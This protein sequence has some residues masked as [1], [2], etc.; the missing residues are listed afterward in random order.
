[1]K[2]P[3]LIAFIMALLIAGAA[4]TYLYANGQQDYLALLA[5]GTTVILLL[6]AY[7][8]IGS[9]AAK[10]HVQHLL[11]L[12]PQRVGLLFFAYLLPYLLFSCG[13]QTFSTPAL[14]K[15]AVF[16]GMPALILCIAK[17][18][19]SPVGWPEAAAMFCIWLPF[20][21]GLL[22]DIWQWPKGESAYVLNAT[23]AVGYAVALFCCYRDVRGVGFDFTWSKEHSKAVVIN[24]T[25]FFIIALAFGI[26]TGFIH[27]NGH[28]NLLKLLGASVG[29]FVFI[30]LPEE[31]LFRGLLQNLLTQKLKKPTAALLITA[32]IFG[33]THLNNGPAPDWRYVVLASVAGFFY[34][35]AYFACRNLMAAAVIHALVDA[36]WV[37]F[38]M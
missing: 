9:R 11:A 5:A 23:M 15:L 27:Y 36:T 30:A 16:L 7:F 32:V 10:T 12:H 38:F 37:T 28:P 3:L 19:R 21:F 24:F 26:P 31:L 29:I 1:M 33:L 34:G 20:D 35:R 17:G 4:V 2:K 22:T 13:T 14:G 25:A 8:A 6:T 18:R